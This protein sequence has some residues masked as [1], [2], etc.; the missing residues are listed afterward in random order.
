MTPQHHTRP[1]TRAAAKLLLA[2]VVLLLP[3]ARVAAQAPKV[4]DVQRLQVATVSLS[5][6]WTARDAK[7]V[8]YTPPPGWYIRS[9][10]V[11]CRERYGLASYAVST[12]PA[13]W[14]ASGEDARAD[15]AKE[16][17]AVGVCPTVP[18]EL[19]S[20]ELLSYSLSPLNMI[21]S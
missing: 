12:V 16:K 18:G 4:G 9:H 11:E 15:A 2:V 17:V 14:D 7:R 10:K 21:V 8:T 3:A 5:V 6:G 1:R 20:N 19:W 13:G